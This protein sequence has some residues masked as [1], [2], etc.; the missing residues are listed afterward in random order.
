MKPQIGF[1][2]RGIPGEAVTEGPPG[3]SEET[4]PLAEPDG[5]EAMTE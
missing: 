4:L 3:I 5:P 2:T 1:R